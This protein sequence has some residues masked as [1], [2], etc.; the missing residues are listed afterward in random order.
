M[1][2]NKIKIKDIKTYVPILI[3]V[4]A[5]IISIRSCDI[6][7]NSLDMNKQEFEKRREARLFV[8]AKWTGDKIYVSRYFK[9]HKIESLVH[10]DLY[11]GLEGFI[12]LN[13]TNTSDH[14]I[15]IAGIKVA[16][17]VGYGL[18]SA[19]MSI[20]WGGTFKSV[21]MQNDIDFPIVLNPYEPFRCITR[22][23]IP[24]SARLVG[25]MADLQSD[26]T[27]SFKDINLRI[28]YYLIKNKAKSRS[29][30]SLE[31]IIKKEIE[32]FGFM[33]GGGMQNVP[34]M[35]IKYSDPNLTVRRGERALEVE[36]KL[37]SGELIVKVLDYIDINRTAFDL[38]SQ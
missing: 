10:E 22:V 28:A 3:S 13:V 4:V 38:L 34:E 5:L 33:T 12:I 8:G 14:T 2:W 23:P 1:I 27:Y 9:G 26:T 21:D 37:S 15:S 31:A 30:D 20:P 24:I 11:E 35:L 7:N 16:Y 29:P 17:G 25:M 36:V 32:S 6:S 19:G 18:K